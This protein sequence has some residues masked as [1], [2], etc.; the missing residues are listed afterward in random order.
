MMYEIKDGQRSG[1]FEGYSR[2]FDSM[3]ES[4]KRIV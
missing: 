1:M 2:M 4:A 3:V